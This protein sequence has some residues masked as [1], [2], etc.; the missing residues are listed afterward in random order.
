MATDPLTTI[1]HLIALAA[2][3]RTPL[4]EARN[5]GRNACVLIRKVNAVVLLEG[6]REPAAAQPTPRQP[7]TTSEDVIGKALAFVTQNLVWDICAHGRSCV[8]TFQQM[9][10]HISK[11]WAFTPDVA[12]RY[13]QEIVSA[14]R[15]HGDLE[16]GQY[17]DLDPQAYGFWFKGPAVQ[18]I[19]EQCAPKRA[20]A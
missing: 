8:T 14:A 7:V 20:V 17:N 12:Q 18:R 13:A 6:M 15:A 16:Y 2:D 19:L 1:K 3:E 10:Q 9:F 5:A 11:K 4:N